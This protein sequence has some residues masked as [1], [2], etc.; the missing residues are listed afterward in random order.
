MLEGLKLR[1]RLRVLD[2][3]AGQGDGTTH[4][5]AI[6]A[7]I[8]S[9]DISENMLKRG[10]EHATI[11]TGNAIRFDLQHFPLPFKSNSFDVV[12]LRYAAHDVQDKASLLRDIHRLL[13]PRG[14]IQ[15]V[16]MS[17]K[18]PD[19][20]TFYNELHAAKTRGNR[21][22]CW[23]LSPSAYRQLLEKAGFTIRSEL[24]YRSRVSSLDWLAEEQITPERHEELR[25]FVQASFSEH[26]RLRRVFH[27]Q[28]RRTSFRIEFP[29][30]C[31]TAESRK[32][33]R[34]SS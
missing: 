13:V 31:L 6:G 8:V 22:P 3:G 5:R 4:L 17:V 21:I 18:D 12:V 14:C 10:L 19:A 16:D 20:L 1:L 33:R 29:V 24:W 9:A 2:L 23:V 30:V 15:F 25:E 27:G 7:D 32:K 34:S 28:V 26:P 11:Q